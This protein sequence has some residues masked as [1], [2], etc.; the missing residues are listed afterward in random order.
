MRRET[1]PRRRWTRSP[2][3][4]ERVSFGLIRATHNQNLVLADVPQ[5]EL[6]GV[7]Q[8]L[9][10]LGLATPNIG[11]LTDMIACPGLDFCSLANAG[12]LDVATPDPASAS[13]TSTTSTTSARSN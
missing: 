8:A 12:T 1:S 7:W 13:M 6:Y 2:T 4:A 10:A 3:L 9:E 11:T 5:R